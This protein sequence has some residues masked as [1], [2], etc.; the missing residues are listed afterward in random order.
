M[1][2][3]LANTTALPLMLVVLVMMGGPV[4]VTPPVTTLVTVGVAVVPVPT[5]N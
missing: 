1:V 2:V 3:P 5:Q 4:V